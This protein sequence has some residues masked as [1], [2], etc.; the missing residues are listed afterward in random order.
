[1]KTYTFNANDINTSS[2]LGNTHT[3]YSEML[4]NII[5]NDK[6]DID[7]IDGSNH[8]YEGKEELVAKQ[9]IKFINK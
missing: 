2:F 8:S 6:K 3:N 7:Y 5:I 9:I 4:N 1:M